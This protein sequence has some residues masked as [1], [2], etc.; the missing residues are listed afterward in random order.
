M[1]RLELLIDRQIMEQRLHRFAEVRR[2]SWMYCSCLAGK[3]DCRS[4]NSVT[5]K[6]IAKEIQMNCRILSWYFQILDHTTAKTLSSS[7]R[8]WT[9]LG[10]SHGNNQGQKSRDA[11]KWYPFAWNLDLSRSYMNNENPLKNSARRC[12]NDTSS[13]KRK[14]SDPQNA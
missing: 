1:F 5:V 8:L 3:G 6:E 2:Y 4:T 13:P 14:Q 9:I 10:S 7:R 12:R 11:N